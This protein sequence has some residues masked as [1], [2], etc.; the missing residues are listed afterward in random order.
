MSN[1]NY[2]TSSYSKENKRLDLPAATNSLLTKTWSIIAINK[3][4]SKTI[5]AEA[6]KPPIRADT[7]DRL[8]SVSFRQSS[9]E[10]L[11]IWERNRAF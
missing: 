4:H 7:L 5:V 11:G 2:K 6:I 1:G 10:I 9:I 3:A 8:Q